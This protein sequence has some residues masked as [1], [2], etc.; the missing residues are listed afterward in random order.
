M[1]SMEKHIETVIMCSVRHELSYEYAFQPCQIFVMKSL[2][3]RHK[4][5]FT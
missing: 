5:K 2:R 4:M 3:L 1:G